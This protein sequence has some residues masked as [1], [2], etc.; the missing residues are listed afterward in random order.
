MGTTPRTSLGTGAV[1]ALNTASPLEVVA[2]GRG[3]PLQVTWHGQQ[4]AV[5]GLRDVWQI[6]DGW[7]RAPEQRVQRQYFEVE[8]DHGTLLTL[9]HDLRQDTWH[10]QRA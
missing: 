2:D 3:V 6:D 7:W 10:A 9:Y 5:V 4:L 1:R 8:L